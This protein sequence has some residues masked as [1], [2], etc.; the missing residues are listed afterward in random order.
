MIHQSLCSSI[1]KGTAV[2]GRALAAAFFIIGFAGTGFAAPIGGDGPP[3][4]AGVAEVLAEHDLRNPEERAAAVAAIR[5]I[6]VERREAAR[7][8]ALARGLP[9]RIERADGTVKEIADI[10][11]EERLLYFI[12]HNDNAAISTGANI[13]QGSAIGLDGVGILIGMWDGGAGRAS[14]QE[15]SGGRLQI[16]DGSS[17]INHATHVAGTLAAAGVVA[18]AKGMSPAAMVQSYDWNNDKSEMTARGATGPGQTD[19]L[20]LSNHSYGFISGWFRTGGS[21]PAYIWYGSGSTASS[22]DPRFGQYNTQ[23]RDS[24]ALAFNA[25]YYLMFRSAGNDRADNPSNGQSVQLSPGSTSTVT[26]DSSIHPP[27]DG[28]YRGGFDTISFDAVAKNVMT[29]GSVSDAVS[30]GQ[31]DVSRAFVSNFSSW[32]PTDDGRIKPDIVANGEVLYSTTNGGNTSYGNLSGTSM[33]APNAAGTAAL[34][35]QKYGRLFPGE[36]MRASTLKGLLIHTA[37]DLGNPGPDYRYGWGLLNGEAAAALM[38]DHAENPLKIRMTEN[39][40]TSA[41]VSASHE[42]VWDGVSPIRATLSW[43]DPAGSATTAHDNRSSRLRN[44]L[45]LRV[46]GPDGSAHYPYVMP[47]VGT[48]TPESMNLPAT[49]GVNNTDNVEQVYIE[50]PPA[51]GTYRAVISFQGTLANNQQVYSLLV[52]GSAAEEPPPPPL[53]VT[54]VS[55]PTGSSG[56]TVTL[57][58]SGTALA[59]ATGARLT[60]NGFADIPAANLRVVGDTLRAEVDLAGAAEGEWNLEVFNAD[61]TAVLPNA[62]SVTVAIFSENFDGTVNGWTTQAVT[63]SNAWVLS[64]AQAHTPPTSYF[65]PGPSTLTTTRLTSPPISIPANASDLQLKFWHNFNL[66]SPRDGGRLEISTDNG[67]SWFGVE[68]AGSG[69][70]FASN[71]YNTLI[72][73]IGRPNTRTEFDRLEAWSGNSNGF[74]ETVLNLTDTAKFADRTLRFRWVIATDSSVA[75]HGWYLDS[76]VL[77]G[78]G[79]LVNQAPVIVSPAATATDESVTEDEVTF[80]LVP[81]TSVDASVEATD[82]GGPENLTYTWSASGPAP[83]FFLPNASNA[84]SSTTASFEELGDYEIT[85][86]VTDAGGL[87]T[88][89]GVNVRVV[90]LA[91]ALEIDPRSAS[92]PFGESLQFSATLLDQF[93]TPL[94]EQPSS[95]SWSATG[96]GISGDGLFT[97]LEVGE[98]FTVAASAPGDLAPD[99]ERL[100]VHGGITDFALVTV[101]PLEAGVMLGSLEQI[102]DGSP[103]EVA[104][105]TDP[106]GLAVSVTYDDS[107]EPPVNAGSYAVEAVVVEPGYQGGASGTLEVGKAVATVSLGNLEQVFDGTPRGVTASTEPEGLAVVVTYDGELEPPT[108]VGSYAVAAV[109]DD[110][111]YEGGASGT[112]E[113]LPASEEEPDYDSWRDGF[114]GENSEENPDAAPGADPDRDGLNNWVEF[115]LGTDPLDPDSRLRFSIHRVSGGTDLQLT[116]QPAVDRGTF[117]L[118]TAESPEG[119]W[120]EPVEIPVEAG[121]PQLTLPASGEGGRQVYRLIYQA[122][123]LP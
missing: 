18:R 65:A 112:L 6:Q 78:G 86:T 108:E 89:S 122:P 58:I 93:N 23:A 32:G 7:Q 28:V 119:P 77:S 54:G 30:S 38:R 103:R 67:S 64:T 81:G 97:A 40:L 99:G 121:V 1:R 76:I 61:E 37:D 59:T 104:V 88:T 56:N 24:D 34:L 96:G 110:P 11:E 85:V 57:D 31:R 91:T 83:A 84:A 120:A 9:E 115:H 20:Y 63:G 80:H 13:L 47:F 45:D 17:P 102:F 46:I 12:T 27:G 60:R 14:H 95:F 74:I 70:V 73:D 109:V 101:T 105:T 117:F 43:T 15:F 72:R 42:F 90:P 100:T 29:V 52:S 36:A 21:S 68:D 8:T 39:L 26:Y 55:P 75:S 94:A 41:A 69:V 16:M 10:D 111:N 114:F 118:Q 33:S 107:E 92:L 106:P 49:T 2:A 98:N 116:V 66:Q 62:F 79:D 44:N 51:P 5:E 4:G 53:T 22:S 48:W 113:V 50:S 71:G 82:D 19:K 25:P 87:S 3:P 35:I 123:P